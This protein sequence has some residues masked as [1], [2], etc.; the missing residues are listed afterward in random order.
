MKRS[1]AKSLVMSEWRAWKRDDVPVDSR[2]SAK[3]AVVFFQFLQRERP[4][5]LRF[6]YGGDRWQIVH[7]W[8]LRAR[9]VSDD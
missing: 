7:S 4:D 8:L 9:E 2:P 5:S 1:E 3:D 6:R